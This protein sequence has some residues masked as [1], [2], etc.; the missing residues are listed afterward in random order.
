MILTAR[1]T[2]S[3]HLYNE[4]LITGHSVLVSESQTKNS[5]TGAFAVL[6]R[7]FLTSLSADSKPALGA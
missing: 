7:L 5:E 6:V 2:L 4:F 1:T 3:F